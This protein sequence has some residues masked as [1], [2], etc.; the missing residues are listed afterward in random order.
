MILV[1]FRGIFVLV[2]DMWY[3]GATEKCSDRIAHRRSV[4]RAA[5]TNAF[6]VMFMVRY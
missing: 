1:L 6:A 2:R 3:L 4:A 5:R